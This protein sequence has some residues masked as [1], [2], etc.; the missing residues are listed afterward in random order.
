MST[1]PE[2]VG[3]RR[4]V[5]ER[6]RKNARILRKRMDEVGIAKVAEGCGMSKSWVAAQYNENRD[7]QGLAL[8]ELDLK[9]VPANV[10]CYD[11][12]FIDALLTFAQ[13]LLA[14]MKS[15]DD[16]DWDEDPE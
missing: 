12:K 4:N 10:R 9:L 5:Q 7:A 11:P 6:A 3:T 13:P 1:T 16:L 15:A 8:A 2:D 14:R